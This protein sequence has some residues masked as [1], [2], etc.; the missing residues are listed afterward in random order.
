[1]D[2]RQILDRITSSR[3]LGTLSPNV[4]LNRTQT[5]TTG[6]VDEDFCGE[7]RRIF[8]R[9]RGNR[10]IPEPFQASRTYRGYCGSRNRRPSHNRRQSRGAASGG[11]WNNGTS[12]L[13]RLIVKDVYLLNN[14]VNSVPRGTEK[15][16]LFK[17]N[18]VITAFKIEGYMSAEA[19][20]CKM[21]ST[22][23]SVLDFSKPAPR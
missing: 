17:T 6:D 11:K 2:P 12:R 21:E 10:N 7:R 9:G 4:S 13:T 18:Q 3:A 22:F 16:K 19:L 20:Y 8:T 23:K 14:R 1:M 5:N 15:T